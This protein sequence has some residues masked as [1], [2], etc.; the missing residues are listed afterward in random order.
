MAHFYDY[1]VRLV[2]DGELNQN[3]QT[4]P[5]FALARGFAV[6][7]IILVRIQ[8]KY[9]GGIS[10]T[11]ISYMTAVMHFLALV[12]SII[13]FFNPSELLVKTVR[14]FFSLLSIIFWSKFLYYLSF[15]EQFTQLVNMM[16]QIV[17]GIRMFNLLLL[18]V[19]FAFANAFYF[20]G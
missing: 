15:L 6:I 7:Q 10:D 14:V 16:Y 18:I 4:T 5:A 11:K 12:C 20:I 1:N 13:A 3:W 9:S 19:I 17:W 2:G 8:T